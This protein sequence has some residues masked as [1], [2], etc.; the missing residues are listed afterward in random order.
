MPSGNGVVRWILTDPTDASTFEFPI[1]PSDGGSPDYRKNITY[2][3]T[4]GAG[5][6]VLAFEGRDAVKQM[7]VTGTILEQQHYEDMITWFNK[8][9]QLTLTDDLGRS[10]EI[11]ITGFTPRR[12]RSAIYPYKHEYTLAYTELDW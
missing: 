9:Y 12:R 2:T 3:N 8:R 6:K 7:T 1:N 4:A 11:Y 5:G 10:F